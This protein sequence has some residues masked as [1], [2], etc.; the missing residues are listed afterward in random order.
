LLLYA[1]DPR[2]T[3]HEPSRAWLEKA[4]SGSELVRFAWVT[5]WTFLR[6]TTS[7]RVYEQ[8]LSAVEAQER[9]ESWLAQPVAGLLE[10]GERHWE[11][12]RGLIRDGQASGPLIM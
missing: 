2:A 9:V 12:L 7:S 1:Y 11:I 3:H 8:P 5:I 10:P 6:I 4:L